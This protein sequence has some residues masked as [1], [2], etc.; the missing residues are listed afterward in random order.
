MLRHVRVLKRSS[1]TYIYRKGTV[2][3][4]LYIVAEGEVE[5][6]GTVET[7][8]RQPWSFIETP[9]K[10][11]GRAL[12]FKIKNA[13]FRE[14]ELLTIGQGKLFGDE[15]GLDSESITGYSF[16]V[17]SGYTKLL[18]IDKDVTAINNNRY[19]SRILMSL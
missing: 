15:N 19:S 11:E 7:D 3:R 13:I 16:R 4:N 9:S 14:I 6:L 2:N 5:A 8:Y 17:R 12:S 18:S 10:S 1:G